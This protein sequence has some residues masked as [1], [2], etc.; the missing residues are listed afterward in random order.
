MVVNQNLSI[1]EKLPSIGLYS[2]QINQI[3]MITIYKQLSN[4]IFALWNVFMSEILWYVCV[5]L[6]IFIGGKVVI[7]YGG[8]WDPRE[9]GI[10]H[11]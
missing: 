6:A 8:P 1:Q 9:V 10:S 2:D 7:N 5:D 3:I 11:D 4:Q